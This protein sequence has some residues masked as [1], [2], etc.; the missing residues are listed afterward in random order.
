MS[1]DFLSTY[2]AKDMEYLVAVSYLF[3]FI[4]FWKYVQGGKKAVATVHA[5]AHKPV[6]TAHRPAGATAGWFQLPAGIH[7]H[8]GHTWARLDSDGLV[9]IGIDDFA[10]K[11]VG[12]GK[13]ELPNLGEK[14]AQGEPALEV[15][16][17]DRT[18]SMLSPVDGTVVAV[19]TSAKENPATLNESLRRRV[20]VQGEGESAGCELP[21]AARR[22]PG[23][24]FHRRCGGG[25]GPAYE[26]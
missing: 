26:P 13:L 12:P 23:S 25:S 1:H 9:S 24:S 19:N 2:I 10:A 20:V 21:S 22:Q 18:V 15:G 7:L 11:L 3:I 5:R 16:H 17:D 4:P 14:L 8:P 6:E